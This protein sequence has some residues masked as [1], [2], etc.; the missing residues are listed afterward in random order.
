MATY[1]P[2]YTPELVG[3]FTATAVAIEAHARVKVDSSGKILVAGADDP[4]VGTCFGSAA[5]TQGG[6]A[7]H[8][9]NSPGLRKFV[10]S[11]TISIG[12]TLYGSASGRVAASGTTK[13]GWV[14]LS[15]GEVGTVIIAAPQA[16]P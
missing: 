6:G 8:Y 12:D 14:A 16:N 2:P 4:W 10:A 1:Q 5:S 9:S 15:A 7:V 13:I 3:A 11:G